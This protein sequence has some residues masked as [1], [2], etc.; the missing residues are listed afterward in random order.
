MFDPRARLI[1]KFNKFSVQCVEHVEHSY[2][3]KTIE[4]KSFEENAGII[5]F[6]SHFFHPLISSSFHGRDDPIAGDANVCGSKCMHPRVPK[7]Q[8]DYKRTGPR[9]LQGVA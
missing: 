4:S 7:L 2:S 5:W 3:S 1:L 8:W 6:W 9:V